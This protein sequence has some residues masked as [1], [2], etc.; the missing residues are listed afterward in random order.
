LTYGDEVEGTVETAADVGNI[1][2]KG[3]LVTEEVEHLVLGVVL[4]EVDTRTDVGTILVLGDEFEVE[5]VA[6]GRDTVGGSVVGTLKTALRSA[7]GAGRADGT[8]PR[9]AVV[10]VGGA[11][12][13]VSPS[14]VGVDDDGAGNVG[15]AA[16][17]GALLPGEA[18]VGLG[19]L[20]ADLLGGDRTKDHGKSAELLEHFDGVFVYLTRDEP[21]TVQLLEATKWMWWEKERARGCWMRGRK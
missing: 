12:D 13:G 21:G 1:D 18:G 5:A 3:E 16:A 7:S 9:V 2:I 15:A 6:A 20:G 11:G 8:V 17:S 4:H 19:S 14:P 10:A